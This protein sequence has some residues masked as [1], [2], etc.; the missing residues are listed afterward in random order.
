MNNDINKLYPSIFRYIDTDIVS[1]NN[2]ILSGRNNGKNYILKIPK[3]NCKMNNDERKKFIEWLEQ[4]KEKIGKDIKAWKA[5]ITCII[6]D[7]KFEMKK[8][9][10]QI[11]KRTKTD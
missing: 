1:K 4:E 2:L 9:R 8:E 11:E 10:E 5:C 7:L 6:I 3:E